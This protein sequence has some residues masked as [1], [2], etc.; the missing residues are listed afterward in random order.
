MAKALNLQGMKLC[1]FPSSFSLSLSSYLRLGGVQWGTTW[2]DSIGCDKGTQFFFF[3]GGRDKD[4]ERF[5]CDA[6]D[7]RE[8][9]SARDIWCPAALY[10]L[11]IPKANLLIISK[12]ENLLQSCFTKFT[13]ILLRLQR[14]ILKYPAN[15]KTETRMIQNLL[16]ILTL[17]KGDA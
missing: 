4:W 6:V 9:F 10:F 17:T 13:I 8:S 14:V 12:R 3:P 5:P 1:R 2:Q 15:K 16:R 11:L 7:E